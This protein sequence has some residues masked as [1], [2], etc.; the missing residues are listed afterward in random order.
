MVKEK[1]YF[2]LLTVN[3]IFSRFILVIEKQGGIM[4]TELIEWLGLMT[5]TTIMIYLIDQT[6]DV[7]FYIGIR[8]VKRSE[9]K[10]GK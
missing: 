8:K 1:Y 2:K 9:K 6:T 3:L 7:M 5:F 4:S 10:E